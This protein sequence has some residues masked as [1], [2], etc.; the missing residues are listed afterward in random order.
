MRDH[1]ARDTLVREY[2]ARLLEAGDFPALTAQLH[3]VIDVLR[4]EE[5]SMQSLANVV[6]SDYGLTLKV[7][8]TVNSFHYNRS[9]RRVLS[10]TQAMVLLG[11]EN[12]RDLASSL[13]LL[14]H[15]ARKAPALKQ[16]MA[17]SML[18]ASHARLAAEHMRYSR[19]EQVRL[20]AMFRN[21]GEVLVACHVP[22]DYAAVLARLQE[23]RGTIGEATQQILGFR[24]EDLGAA[25]CANWGL[26]GCGTAPPPGVLSS[27]LDRLVGF[28]HDLTN[29]VYRQVPTESPQ[30]LTLIL[31]RYGHEL[32]L[33]A[34]SLQTILRDGCVETTEMFAN[35][36]LSTA[37]LRLSRLVD[38]AMSSLAPEAT[39]SGSANEAAGTTALD[40]EVVRGPHAPEARQQ[41]IRELE[42]AVTD[43]GH[44]EVNEVLLTVLEA[45]VRAGPF[46][47]SA[48]CLLSDTRTELVGRFGLGEGVEVLVK[49]LRIPMTVG[50]QGLGVGSA[51]LRR[52]DLFAS[53]ARNPGGDEARLLALLGSQSVLVLPLVLDH[54]S[55]GAIVADRTNTA[56]PPDAAAVNVAVHLRDIAVRAMQRA[57]VEREDAAKVIARLGPEARRDIVLRL[58]RG[59]PL[60]VVSRESQVPVR[61]LTSWKATFLEAATRAMTPGA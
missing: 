51:L 44:F 37:D 43:T 34:E 36:G 54:R 29:A 40:V 13:V 28:G 23:R 21:V 15:Y 1:G 41:L 5:T 52:I 26:D 22:E 4:Q 56:D 33:N 6:L 32:G 30:S 14:E 20:A 45:V 58:L 16:L 39:T 38:A 25:A 10:V 46:S 55:V 12:V 57:R 9:G 47:R 48:L 50:P 7:L 53:L 49:R 61:D 2:L 18:T 42:V 35:M 24:F 17:L 59:E 19:P 60:E 3:D 27:E 11:V 8:Q 31:Q